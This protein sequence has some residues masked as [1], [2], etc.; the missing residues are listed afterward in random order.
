MLE[1]AHICHLTLSGGSGID[2]TELGLLDYLTVTGLWSGGVDP[3]LTQLT[4]GSLAGVGSSQ[5]VGLRV[6]VSRGCWRR[7]TLRSTL[8][9]AIL[10]GPH[11]M[12]TIIMNTHERM[13]QPFIT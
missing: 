1:I 11:S 4:Q 2:V 8:H 6:L 12:A 10:Q 7:T 13:P 5:A 3:C 9:G